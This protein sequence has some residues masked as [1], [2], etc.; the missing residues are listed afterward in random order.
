M[1]FLMMCLYL[2][3]TKR[4]SYYQACVYDKD[5]NNKKTNKIGFYSYYYGLIF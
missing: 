3:A 1:Y 2:C 5:E 4:G